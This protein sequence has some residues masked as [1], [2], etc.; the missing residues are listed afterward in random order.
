MT[1]SGVTA[2]THDRDD[3]PT[4]STTLVISQ[5]QTGGSA[6]ATDEFIEI[7]NVGLAPVNLSGYRIVYRSQNGTNDVGPFGSWTTST[8]L[9]PGQYVLSA[10]T[11]YDETVTPD[12]TWNPSIGSISML[13]VRR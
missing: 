3:K 11:S 1:E 5:F 12:V 13:T 10:S 9:Q 4:V 7:H 2:G 8:I 6:I